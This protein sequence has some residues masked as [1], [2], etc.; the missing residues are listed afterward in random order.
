MGV[1]DPFPNSREHHVSESHYEYESGAL[2]LAF[3][4]CKSYCWQF[5]ELRTR[6]FGQPCVESPVIGD[7]GGA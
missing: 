2:R 3:A 1:G 4:P 7:G 6:H 5:A